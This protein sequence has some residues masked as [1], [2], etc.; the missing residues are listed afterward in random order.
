MIGE[1]DTRVST[2]TPYIGISACLTEYA[3]YLTQAGAWVFEMLGRQ[4]THRLSTGCEKIPSVLLAAWF[5]NARGRG[6]RVVRGRR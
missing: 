5:C 4:G 3:A 1:P 2:G 6:E